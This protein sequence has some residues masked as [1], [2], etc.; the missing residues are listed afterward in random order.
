[1]AEGN[2]A[3]V[4]PAP[5][6]VVLPA[7]GYAALLVEA[8]LLTGWWCTHDVAAG[9]RVGH[10]IGWA[11]TAS[12]LLMHV[13]SLRKR[14]PALAHL[15]RLSTWLRWHIFL[16]LQGALLVCFHS[17]HLATLRNISGATI[18]CTLVVVASGMFGRYLYSL[19][20]K[21]LSGERLTARQIEAELATLQPLVAAGRAQH[22]ALAAAIDE[23]EAAQPI[24]GKLGLRA[25]VSE[26]L[27]TRRAL[28]HLNRALA[29]ERRA[30][31]G[32][33][34][35]ALAQATR[36]RGALARRLGMLTAAERLFRGWHLFHKPLTFVLLGAVILHVV[37]HYIYA[38]QFGSG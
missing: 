38:A 22:P 4:A 36:R 20:P 17:A 27:R 14:V 6:E 16:G 23:L 29:V 18:V 37:A 33:E 5:S 2:H 32:P 26:D 25:L 15:G 3:R 13:Y 19:L 11:G 34:L 28:R 31:D 30:H 35:A 21:A 24:T 8:A 7:L 1:M 10:T 9:D 12:M